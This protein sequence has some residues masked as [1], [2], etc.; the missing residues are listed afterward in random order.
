M[1]KA[2]FEEHERKLRER[3]GN[4]VHNQIVYT[5]L[6]SDLFQGKAHNNDL[7]DIVTGDAE[8]ELKR[9]TASFLRSLL[10]RVYGDQKY[11]KILG[12]GF[13]QA[14]PGNQTQA[15][16][17]DYGGK[18][19]NIFI[20]M[21]PMTDLNGTEFVHFEEEGAGEFWFWYLYAAHDFT[22]DLPEL[23]PDN[24]DRHKIPGPSKRYAVR[25]WNAA[26]HTIHRMPY[27]LYHRGP[28]NKEKETKI[29]FYVTVTD[30]PDFDV[31]DHLKA[32][33]IVTG[34]EDLGS[35]QIPGTQLYQ[36]K[37]K[38]LESLESKPPSTANSHAGFLPTHNDMSKMPTHQI[39]SEKLNQRLKYLEERLRETHMSAARAWKSANSKNLG[40]EVSLYHVDEARKLQEE[41]KSAALDVARARVGATRTTDASFTTF[42]LH[43]TTITQAVILAKEFLREY[44]ASDAHPMRFITGRGNRSVGGKGVLG[45]AVYNALIEDGWN[46]SMF[47]GG[48]TIRG[49]IAS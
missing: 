29:V 4:Y 36:E 10:R 28:T 24:D 27:Y 25:R 23:F 37:Q 15:W 8:G 42:D 31:E 11:Q 9:K 14:P 17:T 32:T 20:P 1:L 6:F 34:K 21:V 7:S 19:E 12:F 38:V 26:P 35:D 41:V 18:T 47:A 49:R 39:G 3:F 30:D 43:Y 46:L 5:S 2:L 44:G 48:L 13:I 22:P 16:H 33:V 45:P 40:K